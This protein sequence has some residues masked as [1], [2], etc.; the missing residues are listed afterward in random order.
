MSA[1]AESAHVAFSPAPRSILIV[2]TRRIGDVLLATP[3]VRSLKRAWPGTPIDLLVFAGT[4]GFVKHNPDI[5][6]VITV[7][8]RA[9]WL[10]HLKLAGSLMR[11]YDLALSLVP[12]D[13]PTLYAWL[14]GRRRV[15]LLTLDAKSRWKQYLLDA[16]VPFDNDDTHTVR[17]HLALLGTVGV[18]PL[19]DV[20]PSWSSEDEARAKALLA[21]MGNARY[22][23]I[24][25]YPKFRYKMWTQ[26]GWIEVARW[27]QQHHV[28]VVFTG[29]PD[30]AEVDYVRAIADE[31]SGT[32]DLAGRLTLGG[33]AYV[34]SRAAVYIGPDT[35]ITHA[36]AALGVPTVAVFGPSNPVKW[37]PWPSGHNVATNPWAR[38]GSQSAGSVRLV[39]GA[40]PCVPCGKEGCQRH[41]ESPSDCLTELRAQT[42]IDA[43]RSSM[44]ESGFNELELRPV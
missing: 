34:V 36:A 26:D 44:D 24:H 22:A 25:P 38:V 32:L 35:A 18:P 11:R 28:R 39:Q 8:E 14:A 7:P 17:M 5:R 20:A 42:V 30:A 1:A 13:R 37:A 10:Q 41:I 43:V 21:P 2:V 12:G 4:D 33:V 19:A 16:W 40:G 9:R 15:G 29:G 23:V 3:V 31:V 6:S 27:L